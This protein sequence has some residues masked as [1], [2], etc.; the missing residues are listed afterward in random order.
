MSRNSIA[1]AG[2]VL[3]SASVLGGCADYLNRFDTVTLAAGDAQKHNRLLQTV[4]SFNPDA[5]DTTLDT[6]GNVVVTAVRKYKAPGAGA[7][8]APANVTVNVATPA[9]Q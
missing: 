1:L 2:L 4:D 3:A 6:D 5:E 8:P 7:T 9:G